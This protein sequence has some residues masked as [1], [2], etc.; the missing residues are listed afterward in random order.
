MTSHKFVYIASISDCVSR[1]VSMF[2]IIDTKVSF[3]K[4]DERK[5]FGIDLSLYR[6]WSRKLSWELGTCTCILSIVC[7]A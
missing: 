2:E 5:S 1:V 6:F 3:D 4:S 7:E